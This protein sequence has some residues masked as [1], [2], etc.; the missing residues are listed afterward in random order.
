MPADFTHF[1][2]LGAMRTG[3][4][5]LEDR[6]GAYPG[7]SCHGELFNP[8]FAGRAGQDQLFG[9]GVDRI[10]ADPAGAIAAM[11]RDTDGVPGFRLFADH[12]AQALDHVLTDPS[13]AKII[14]T[15]NPVE[16]FVSLQIARRTDQW[17][18]T[19]AKNRKTARIRFDSARF[20]D[21]LTASRAHYAHLR[22][23]IRRAGQTWFQVDY[24][25]LGDTALI[26]GLARHLGASGKAKKATTGLRKQ[27]PGPL[28][29]KVTNFAQMVADLGQIDP[30]ELF[31][32]ADYEPAAGISYGRFIA[33]ATAPVLYMPVKSGPVDQVTAW[34]AG[35]GKGGAPVSGM[36]QK[37]LRQWKR[38]HKGHRS[39]TV[40][41]HPLPRAFAAYLRHLV[42]PGSDHFPKLREA[43][44]GRY[45]L[46]LPPVAEVADQDEAALRE[47]FLDFLNFL[48]PN[49]AGETGIRVDP[50]WASQSAII[51]GMAEFA[52]P[53]HVLREPDLPL[54]LEHL[55]AG[56]GVVAPAYQPDVRQEA[57]LT[58]LWG[59]DLE[60]AAR[61]AYQRD[62][63][64]F[65]WGRW[66]D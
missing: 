59:D 19:D 27:N 56:L 11:Q 66:R 25:E 23:A 15:R 17:K 10:A 48:K 58:L 26:D 40:I 5:L 51:S 22:Q 46:T 20:S 1:V 14:L 8:A 12:N 42:V 64:I 29:E 52:L 36:S 6:L 28:S 37:A 57:L 21:Y 30:L 44:T 35:L 34:L 2:I 60:R 32:H 47:G 62:Y 63:M 49:I 45:G 39:F 31:S 61:S 9:L 55:C 50:A 4:N 7:L 24:S 13:C 18:L 65:G 54:D 33:A 3:S 41:R 16:S 53:D 43:M 38:Q